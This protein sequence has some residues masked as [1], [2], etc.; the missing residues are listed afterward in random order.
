[1]KN[2]ITVAAFFLLFATGAF[3]QGY[4]KSQYPDRGRENSRIDPRDR[5]DLRQIN[6]LKRQARLRIS[7]GIAN[8]T[9]TNRESIRLLNELERIQIKERRYLSNRSLNNRETRELTQDLHILI[10][11]IHYEKADSEYERNRYS[12]R[13]NY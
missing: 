9:L 11:G 12:Q 5:Q 10:R 7:D 8:G 6:D 2:T 3:A 13:R 4:G 1:M